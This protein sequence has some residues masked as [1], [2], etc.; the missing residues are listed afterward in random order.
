MARHVPDIFRIRKMGGAA[1]SA[2]LSHKSRMKARGRGR[3]EHL[4]RSFEYEKN[5][6][7][8]F[9]EMNMLR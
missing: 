6:F 1:R 2:G 4:A 9:Y 5:T 7:K 8:V 3:M